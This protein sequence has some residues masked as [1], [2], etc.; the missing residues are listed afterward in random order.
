MTLLLNV[1]IRHG[2]W[3][4]RL[5]TASRW[6]LPVVPV[7]FCLLLVVLL[8]FTDIDSIGIGFGRSLGFGMFVILFFP[9]LL[10]ESL[11]L[12]CRKV[13]TMRCHQCPW[14]KDFSFE[15]AR[16]PAGSGAAQ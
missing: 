15:A 12:I 11:V 1:R 9:T 7:L 6:A 3:G 8:G 4:R 16:S 14:E 5:K 13:R 2:K 10:L